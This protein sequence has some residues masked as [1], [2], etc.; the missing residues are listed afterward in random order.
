[1]IAAESSRVDFA[2]K[3]T[4]DSFTGHLA[5]FEAQ[6]FPSDHDTVAQATMTFQV[7]DLKT[8]KDDRDKQMLL[9]LEAKKFPTATFVLK[10]LAPS[11]TQMTATGDLTLHGVTRPISFPVSIGDVGSR[12]TIDGTASIDHREWGLKIIRKLGVLKVDPTVKVTVHLEA[13]A[14]S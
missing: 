14:S 5:K 11:G 10:S 8:G 9:W 7:S 13:T 1:M 2:V 6:I 3:V 12:H 4:V